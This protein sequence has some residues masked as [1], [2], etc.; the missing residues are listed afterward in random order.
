VN[1]RMYHLSDDYPAFGLNAEDDHIIYEV[2]YLEN[3]SRGT[4]LL[5]ALLGWLYVLIPH[6]FVLFFLSIA[7][8]VISF[9]AW[10]VVLFTGKYP[11]EFFRFMNNFLKYNERV[12]LYMS[13]MVDIYPPFSLSAVGYEEEVA[14]MAGVMTDDTDSDKNEDFKESDLV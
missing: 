6:G 13:Y 5:R 2:P 14:Q 10:W 9:I 4:V 8:S 12:G 1:A 3:P 11:I 7:A